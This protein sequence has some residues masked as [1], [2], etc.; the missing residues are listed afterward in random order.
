MQ[1]QIFRYKDLVN[2]GYG[3]RVTIWRAIKLNIIPAPFDFMG[4]PAWLSEE[5]EEFERSRA[6]LC[7]GKT[8]G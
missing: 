3:T 4:R 1:K 2:R 6:G 7:E 8:D 5:I